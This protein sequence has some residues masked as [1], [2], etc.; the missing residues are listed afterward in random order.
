M[1]IENSN[2]NAVPFEQINEGDTFM[3]DNNI[4]MK[5]AI[6]NDTL[7]GI[8]NAVDMRDGCSIYFHDDSIVY[9]V[10]GKFII[11]RIC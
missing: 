1:K 10:E 6:V 9:P 3:I 8:L 5:I 4:Y 11:E 2:L 7:L